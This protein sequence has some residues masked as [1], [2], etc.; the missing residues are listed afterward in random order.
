MP[1]QICD[2]FDDRLNL[3]NGVNEGDYYN[4][5]GLYNNV[6]DGDDF[7]TVRGIRTGEGR[8]DLKNAMALEADPS[9]FDGGDSQF[10]EKH[11]SAATEFCFGYAFRS[12]MNGNPIVFYTLQSGFLWRTCVRIELREYGHV[13]VK[14][15]VSGGSTTLEN[16][17][18]GQ[19]LKKFSQHGWHYMHGIMEVGKG[20]N[21]DSLRIWI[22]G[23]EIITGIN[24]TL[25]QG[26]GGMVRCDLPYSGPEVDDIYLM[27]GTLSSP[28]EVRI[29]AS[30]PNGAGADANFT[31]QGASNNWETVDEMDQDFDTTYNQSNGTSG[32]RDS[33]T[34][35]PMSNQVAA[36]ASIPA[37]IVRC[38]ASAN[39]SEQLRPYLRISGTRYYGTAFSPPSGRYQY[40]QHIWETNPNTSSPWTLSDLDNL[41]IGYEVV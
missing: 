39:A 37:V 28:G 11:F 26:Y 34:I 9:E 38:M 32:H 3:D 33:F 31:P 22:D 36:A 12:T 1:I 40:G 18:V 10:I 19:G 41:E 35:Q 14:R 17:L 30:F 24:L 8:Y 21:N 23:V 13:L 20:N 4:G 6:W 15:R 25:S 16:Y 29:L 27:S 5:W 2:G 7:G